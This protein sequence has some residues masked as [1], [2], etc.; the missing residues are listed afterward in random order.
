RRLAG[1]SSTIRISPGNWLGFMTLNS[2]INP[3]LFMVGKSLILHLKCS[4]KS[5][6]CHDNVNFIPLM[7]WYDPYHS[8]PGILRC[9]YEV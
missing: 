8:F 6:G 2:G 7:F 3:V 5:G 4:L 1:V 9:L